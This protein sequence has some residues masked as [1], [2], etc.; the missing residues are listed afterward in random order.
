M[1]ENEL[2]ELL[3]E[4]LILD[5]AT[6]SGNVTLSKDQVIF[7]TIQYAKKTGYIKEVQ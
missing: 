7:S 3:Q 6:K 5:I 4:C 2:K 1:S